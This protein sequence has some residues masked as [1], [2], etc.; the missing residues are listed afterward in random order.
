MC[1]VYTPTLLTFLC[2]F[3]AQDD[4]TKQK[5][6]LRRRQ[7]LGNQHS[8]TAAREQMEQDIGAPS[9][10]ALE[11]GSSLE[12]GVQDNSLNS[13]TGECRPIFESCS[14]LPFGSHLWFLLT[15]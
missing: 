4:A 3:C 12:G 14:Y 8:I 7:G 1:R 2:V 11:G 5:M 6:E 10:S 9:V 15:I 13:I